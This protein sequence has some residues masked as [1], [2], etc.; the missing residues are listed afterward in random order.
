MTFTGGTTE[1][2]V[3]QG[4]WCCGRDLKQAWTKYKLEVLQLEST[5]SSSSKVG[6]SLISLWMLNS[7]W[8][9]HASRLYV[10]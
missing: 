9:A 10:W 2:H 8:A 1:D 7:K 5:G 3:N 4:S 6:T